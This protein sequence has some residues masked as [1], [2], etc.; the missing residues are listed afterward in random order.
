MSENLDLSNIESDDL[1][2]DTEDS[3]Y[4]NLIYNNE[5]YFIYSLKNIL[6]C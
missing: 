5:K 1:H 2:L 3:D 6:Y 4:E